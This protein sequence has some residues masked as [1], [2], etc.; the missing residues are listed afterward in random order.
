MDLRQGRVLLRKI[1]AIPQG[2]TGLSAMDEIVLADD[3]DGHHR[4][5][6]KN[7]RC[8]Y[9]ISFRQWFLSVAEAA[10]LGHLGNDGL[11]TGRHDALEVPSGD[12]EVIIQ[13]RDRPNR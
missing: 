2:T 13:D 11:P 6:G 1:E 9:D 5:V 3:A 8:F 7:I 4:L 10:S 12:Y